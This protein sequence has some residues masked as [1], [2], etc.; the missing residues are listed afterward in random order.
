MHTVRMWTRRVVADVSA[1][2]DDLELA[3]TES[4]RVGVS[5]LLSH[6]W[7]LTQMARRDGPGCG[8]PGL[9][10]NKPNSAVERWPSRWSPSGQQQGVVAPGGRHKE[11]PRRGAQ[12]YLPDHTTLRVPKDAA[13]RRIPSAASSGTH[14]DPPMFAC[15]GLG[16]TLR[17]TT[18]AAE[19]HLVVASTSKKPTRSDSPRAPNMSPMRALKGISCEP[20][21]MTDCNVDDAPSKSNNFE[22]ISSW[23]N[24]KV[25]SSKSFATSPPPRALICVWSGV[26]WILHARERREAGNRRRPKFRSATRTRNILVPLQSNCTTNTRQIQHRVGPMQYQCSSQMDPLRYQRSA[27]APP[28][29]YQSSTRVVRGWM[30][31]RAGGPSKDLGLHRYYLR[32]RDYPTTTTRNTS[33]STTSSTPS[34]P[35]TYPAST[36][37]TTTFTTTTTSTTT[38]TATTTTT[39]TTVRGGGAT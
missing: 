6:T 5:G 16:I 31:G 28:T 11:T 2:A 15:K 27:I 17:N 13:M 35:I 10:P 20:L 30:D 7:S 1:C 19:V 24:W 22:P 8:N 23:G 9:P 33:T 25:A 18:Y 26:R 38:N 36:T 3:D 37:S 39:T 29:Q 34:T 32:D 14:S 12:H 4:L 21:S